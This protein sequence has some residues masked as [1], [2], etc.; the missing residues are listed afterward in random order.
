MSAMRKAMLYDKVAESSVR[1]NLCAHRCVIKDGKKGICQVREN[2]GRVS[3]N[4]G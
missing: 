1:C 4:P 3:L 2:Q